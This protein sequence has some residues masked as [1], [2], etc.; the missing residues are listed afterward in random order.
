MRFKED[1]Q[2]SI[3]TQNMMKIQETRIHVGFARGR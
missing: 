2:D 1:D 3:A